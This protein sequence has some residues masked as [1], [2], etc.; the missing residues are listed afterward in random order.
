MTRHT[1]I[2]AEPL[3]MSYAYGQA[4]SAADRQKADKHL[5][6]CADCRET[7]GFIRQS[8]KTTRTRPEP[9]DPG[10]PHPDPALIVALEADTL[11]APTS[12]HVSAHIVHCDSCREEFLTLLKWSNERVEERALAGDP[13]LEAEIADGIRENR[14]R[15]GTKIA[16]AAKSVQQS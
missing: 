10:E 6:T 2:A 15:P 3:V 13:E 1:C 4:L 8:L 16:D 9:T 14:I 11:D 7:V 5:G 12:E